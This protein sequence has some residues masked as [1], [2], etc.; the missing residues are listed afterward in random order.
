MP[1]NQRQNRTRQLFHQIKDQ[2]HAG[3]DWHK[4]R[5]KWAGY[6]TVEM[7]KVLRVFAPYLLAV[8]DNLFLITRDGP[9]IVTAVNDAGIRLELLPSLSGYDWIHVNQI[10][11]YKLQL[12]SPRIELLDAPSK[13]AKQQ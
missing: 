12:L 1:H 11:E 8:Y 3:H 4:H 5:I 7:T 10:R 13:P 9:G 6:N 2:Y